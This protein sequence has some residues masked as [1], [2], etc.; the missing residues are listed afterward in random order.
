MKNFLLLLALLGLQAAHAQVVEATLLGQWSRDDLV[1]SIY[2]NNT[3]NDL[4]GL[5]IGDREYAVIGS[6]AGTHFI[7]VTNPPNLTEVA[8]VPGTAQG[9]QI[10]HRDYKNYGCYLYGVCDEGAST[11]QIMDVSYLPDSVHLVYN[12][13]QLLIRSHNIFID[14][15]NAMLYTLSTKGGPPQNSA[16]RVYSLANPELPEYINEYSNFGGIQT[17]SVH[18]A[19]VRNGIAYLDCGYDGF[20]IV[21]FTNPASPQTLGTLTDYP[22]AGYNHS[23]WGSDD[24]NYVFMGDENHGYKLKSVRVADPTNIEVVATFNADNSNVNSIPHNQLVACDYLYVSYYYDGLQ[25]YDVSDPTDP[26]R[27]M[28]YPTSTRPFTNSYEGAWGV[29]PFL[30]SG[31]IL[32]SDMQN[33]LF[34]ISGPSGICGAKEITRLDCQTTTGTTTPS[35]IGTWSVYPQP[36]R[37]AFTLDLT[38]TESQQMVKLEVLDISGRLVQRYDL[39]AMDAGR[40][41]FPLHLIPGIAPGIYLLRLQTQQGQAVQKM[42]VG[43]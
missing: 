31:K 5:S 13:N 9:G 33:G 41:S 16:M 17:S 1:G 43:K 28:F 18:D 34:V 36:T 10:V 27:V 19:Y 30:P 8:F 39:G 6:T 32:V 23:C 15:T 21:D 40:Q 4:W 7:D 11:L 12:S 37:D 38:L 26:R 25:V 14:T 35:S 20:A 3:Y 29:Y 22:F 42:V 24:G 2:Y